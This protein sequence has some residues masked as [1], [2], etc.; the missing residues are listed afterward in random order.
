[1]SFWSQ[2]AFSAL[3]I[4]PPDARAAQRKQATPRVNSGVGIA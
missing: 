4:F 1:M 3:K 2:L